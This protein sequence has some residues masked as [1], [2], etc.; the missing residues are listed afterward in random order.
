MEHQKNNY[1]EPEEELDDSSSFFEI[2]LSVKLLI[3]APSALILSFCIYMTY[4]YIDNPDTFVSPK[5]LGLTSIFIFSLTAVFLVWFPWSRLGIRITKIGGIEFKEIVTNQASEHAEEIGYL[6]DRIETLE[7]GLR[8]VDE[9]SD[10]TESFKEPDLR[11]LLLEFLTKYKQWAFSP[12]RIRAWGSQQ[13][14]FS[15]L[16]NY[17]HPFIRSTLQKMASE[18]V[19]ETTISKKGN[20]LYR[21]AKP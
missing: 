4:R 15:P 7:A 9:M 2:P 12:S 1:Q 20:T 11:N 21:V 3:T 8:R 6:E 19:L 16:S 14:G 17:E 18:N 10:F 5:D 13:Q